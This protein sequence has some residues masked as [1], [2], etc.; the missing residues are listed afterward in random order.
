MTKRATKPK[1]NFS[2]ELTRVIEPTGG[3]DVELTTLADAARF[4]GLLK[5]WRQAWPHWDH[6]AELIL[7]AAQTRKKID[8]EAATAQMERALRKDNWL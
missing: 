6:A 5:P 8:I 4:V 3:P 2:L 1:A 7:K